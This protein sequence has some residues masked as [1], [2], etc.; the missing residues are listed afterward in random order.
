[1]YAMARDGGLIGWWQ[2]ARWRG[3]GGHFDGFFRRRQCLDGF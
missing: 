1:M 3:W 2:V